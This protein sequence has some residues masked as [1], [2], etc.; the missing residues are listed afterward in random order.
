VVETALELFTKRI[1]MALNTFGS[2]ISTPESGVWIGQLSS[3]ERSAFLATFAGWMLDG[4]DVMVYSLVLPILLT[5]WHISKGQA[6]LLSTATLLIS[7]LGGWIAGILADRFGRVQLLK[8][9]VFWF[10][11]F[12]FISGFTQNFEQLFLARSMQGLG[13]GGEWAVG[14]ALMSETIRTR[15]RGRA[16]G[17]VQS[18]WS[19]GWGFSV[20]IFMVVFSYLP[21]EIAWRVMFWIGILPALL[22]VYIRRKVQEPEV[23]RATTEHKGNFLQIF[24]PALLRTTLFVSLLS[25]GAQGGY[26]AVTTWLPLYLT[27]SRGLTTV[28]S[29]SYLFVVICGAF[30]GYLTAAHLTDSIG[31][32]YTLTLFAACSFL[33]VIVYTVFPMSNHL[34]LALGFPLGFFP[35]GAFSPM[36]AYFSELFPTPVR[37]S[38]AGFGYNLGRGAGAL[39]PTMVGFVSEHTSLGTAIAIFGSGAYLIMI[40]GTLFLPETR[41]KQLDS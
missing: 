30:V 6:G 18:G 22:I 25:L 10:A 26:H 4:M 19:I 3:R 15:Y 1:H 32:K 11:L 37:A 13:F 17:T 24:S 31:R 5:A 40:V 27:S 29:G 28:N 8:I 39:F 16:V 33:T 35:S 9:T 2:E 12:T 38:G 34:M 41:G 7:S 23:Y 20:L 21:H 14:A 36:G